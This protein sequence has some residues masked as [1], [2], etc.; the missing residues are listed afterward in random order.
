M[1]PRAVV[2]NSEQFCHP[3]DIWQRLK[4]SPLCGS[5]RK[6]AT[7]TGERPAVLLNILQDTGKTLTTNNYPVQN[8]NSGK[9]EKPVP[10]R[11]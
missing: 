5:G 8:V 7:F 6:T 10:R 1:F 4:T 3:E 2:F 11:I 9:I